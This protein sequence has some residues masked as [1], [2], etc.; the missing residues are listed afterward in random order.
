[1]CRNMSSEVLERTPTFSNLPPLL[2]TPPSYLNEQL[3]LA[4]H[5]WHF[6]KPSTCPFEKGVGVGV[7]GGGSHYVSALSTFARYD[8]HFTPSLNMHTLHR[9]I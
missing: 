6:Y 9:R 7:G 2:S 3:R 4:H 8:N 5:N 1:M